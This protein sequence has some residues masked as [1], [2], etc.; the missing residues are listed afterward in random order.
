MNISEKY[1]NMCA[2]AEEIQFKWDYRSG[3]LFMMLIMKRFRS[4]SSTL[5]EIIHVMFGYLDKTNYKTFV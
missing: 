1:I 5:Q 3:D 2:K 4:C